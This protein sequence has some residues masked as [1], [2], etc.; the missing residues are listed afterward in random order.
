MGGELRG[1]VRHARGCL[2]LPVHNEELE[3]A[4]FPEARKAAHRVG[5]EAATGLGEVADARG[6]PISE[7]ARLEKLEGIG[8]ASEGGDPVC[9]GLVPER[10][11]GYRPFSED[12]ARSHHEM[13]VQ[14]GEPVTVMQWERGHC[15]VSG[16]E[17]QI[18]RYGVCVAQHVLSR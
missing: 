11:V 3:S 9:C 5:G 10:R 17:T 13:T 6:Q 4:T 7:L 14:H 2:C 15:P 16:G 18:R 8:D 1:D 12:D